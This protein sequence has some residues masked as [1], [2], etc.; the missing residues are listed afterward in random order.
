[1]YTK[2]IEKVANLTEFKSIPRNEEEQRKQ[3]DL[4]ISILED[5]LKEDSE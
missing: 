3:D 5:L 2:F 4:T 1:L